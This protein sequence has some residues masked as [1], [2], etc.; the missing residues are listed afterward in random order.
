MEGLGFLHRVSGAVGA[1]GFVVG[2]GAAGGDRQCGR[3]VGMMGT[4]GTVGTGSHAEPRYILHT[5]I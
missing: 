3:A 5:I 1:G 2:D 4:A